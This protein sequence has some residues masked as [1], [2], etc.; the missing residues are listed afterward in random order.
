MISFLQRCVLSLHSSLISPTLCSKCLKWDFWRFQLFP[1]S[2][3]Q[4]ECWRNWN[5]NTI[6]HILSIQKSWSLLILQAP[7]TQPHID[8]S[9]MNFMEPLILQLQDGG[10][11]KE[12]ETD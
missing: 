2:Q 9:F 4:T 1:L 6:V 12:M 3:K 11:N 7:T 5:R 10:G 8:L